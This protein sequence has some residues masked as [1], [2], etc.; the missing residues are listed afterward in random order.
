MQDDA[1]LI[2]VDIIERPEGEIRL[3]QVE[4]VA[5]TARSAGGVCDS[6]MRFLALDRVEKR[7]C[8][9]EAGLSR[10]EVV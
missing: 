7:A 6:A 9:S 3:F 8:W 2:W 10:R 1:R 5:C 4:E